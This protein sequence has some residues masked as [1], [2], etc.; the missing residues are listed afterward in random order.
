MLRDASNPTARD[1]GVTVSGEIDPAFE[2]VEAAFRENFTS[3][4]E[5]GA[6][7]CVRIEGRVVVDLW[8]GHLD[9]A[10][11]RPWTRDT[12]VN[13]Y[14][15]GKGL[16]TMLVLALV[17]RGE[18][19]LDEPV[20]RRWP[21]FAAKGKGGTTLR[22]LMAHQAGLPGVRAA[23]PAEAVYDWRRMSDSLAAQAPF[24]TPGEAHGYHVNTHGFLSGELACRALQ[25]PYADA[26]RRTVAA[27]HGADF[28]IGLP[29]AEHARVAP[30]IEPPHPPDGELGPEDALEMARRHFGTGDDERD[31]M[32]ASVYFNPMGLSGVGT[33]NTPDWRRASVPSTNGHGT[34]RAVAQLYDV[35]LHGDPARGGFVGP[36]LRAEA[37]SIVADGIDRVLGKPSRFGVG[38]QLSQPTRRVGGGDRAFG[39]FGYGGTLG[40]A[41]PESGVAFGYLMNRP[42][43]RWQTPR[44]NAVVEAVYA[45]LGRPLEPI[46]DGRTP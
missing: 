10:R 27:P 16:A 37:T 17:E 7:L 23:L 19:D 18:L 36:G 45:A 22:M 34:A 8:G 11:T 29:D 42:G 31:A 1:G 12:L 13:A 30:I 20:E 33:V 9:R 3:R 35:F 15:V 21:E 39:H 6:A 14:S 26:F 38:F 2:G 40:F 28:H 4:D 5:I 44:T 24:W 46:E 25:R 41:D 32:L 43:E